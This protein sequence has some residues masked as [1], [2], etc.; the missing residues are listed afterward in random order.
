MSIKKLLIDKFPGQEET[1]ET[2]LGSN[3]AFDTLADEYNAVSDSLNVM[4]NPHDPASQA[5]AEQLQLRLNDLHE[6]LR[7]LIEQTARV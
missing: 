1:I 7:G 5:A 4:A 3:T 6:E 2:L